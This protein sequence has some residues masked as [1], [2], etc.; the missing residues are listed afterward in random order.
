MSSTGSAAGASI[1]GDVVPLRRSSRTGAAEE[2]RDF[3]GATYPRVVR[4]VWFVVHDHAVAEEIAQDTFIDL[5]RRWGTVR[6]YEQPTAW[7]RRVALRKAQREA[8]RSARRSRLERAAVGLLPVHDGPVALDEELLAA[9][10]SLPPRQRAV[11]ALYYLE[12]L[13]MEEVAEL[14]GCSTSTG[15]VHLHHARTR[16]AR[17]LGPSSKTPEEVDGDVR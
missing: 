6:E 3:F 4:T 1:M 12:D 8:S 10:R 2:F 14:V 16:L 13:P 7:V 11:V 5:Y 9:L 15:Y 17:A